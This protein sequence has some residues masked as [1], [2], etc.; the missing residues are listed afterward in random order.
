MRI[1]GSVKNYP[2][3]YFRGFCYISQT[4]PKT[5]PRIFIFLNTQY[6]KFY[7]L[8]LTLVCATASFARQQ[9]VSLNGSNSN[10]G[11]LSQPFLTIQYGLSQTQPG[12]TL[13]V[14]AGTYHEK[15]TASINGTAA[16]PVLLSAYHNSAVIIDGTGLP[17]QA[18][19]QLV[20]SSYFTITGFILENNY[21]QDAKGIY[22]VGSGHT[23]TVTHT[24]VRNIGW[25]SDFNA[26]PYSVYPT[27]QAHGILIN[28]RT[29][30]GIKNVTVAHCN[31]Y[32][33]VTGNSEA[34]TITGNVDSFL[35]AYDS[36]YNTRNIAIDISGNYSWAVE[37]GVPAHLNK[38]RNGIITH[39][40]T[41]NN[42]RINNA[43][44]PAGIYVDGGSGVQI[45]NNISYHNGN[46]ISVGCEN[47]GLRADSIIVAGNLVYY[48]DNKG[49]L[50]GS[51]NGII[52]YCSA[53]NNTSFNDGTN[54]PF[55]SGIFLQ[56]SDSSLVANNI[57]IPLSNSHYGISI[58]GYTVTNFTAADNL[59]YRFSGNATELVVQTPAGQFTPVNT[60]NTNPF[61]IDTAARDFRLNS[62]SPAVN[63]GNNSW[64][65]PM[66]RDLAD[67]FR[68]VNG[69]IDPGAYEQSTGGC[70]VILTIGNGM[71]LAGK[72][73]AQQK[74]V[75]QHTAS[76]VANAELFFYTPLLEFAVPVTISRPFYVYKTG[77]E[78]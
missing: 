30:T 18:I 62:S 56:N 51:N 10:P 24:T 54:A 11:T 29:V 77:C 60:M 33:L 8:L 20:N 12:D 49:I 41:F 36:V 42:R 69:I 68:L 1:D 70:P 74:I 48:N 31:L 5:K 32:N 7:I 37:Q 22:I 52:K 75:Y 63:A 57:I 2:W 19:L 13:Y 43:D 15:I 16:Q 66:E 38:A 46:G 67:S 26:D 4:F 3:H 23:L 34:L 45:L 65:V 76:T 50:F 61:F 9:F 53:I 44:A 78:D 6:L 25:T 28:G 14:Q 73:T 47:P 72:F 55:N 17:D 21:R 71:K 35:L 27:G 59:I 39:C 40:T 58:F 64:L